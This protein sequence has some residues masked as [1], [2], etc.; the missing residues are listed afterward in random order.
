V[1]FKDNIVMRFADAKKMFE[2]IV[3]S[4]D[5]GEVRFEAQTVAPSW[6]ASWLCLAT[7]EAPTSALRP[8]IG[9]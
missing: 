8:H 7:H 9:L 4:L 5:L 3:K 2:I 1:F 6:R